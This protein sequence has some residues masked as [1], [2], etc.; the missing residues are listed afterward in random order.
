MAGVVC[1]LTAADLE[2]I[3]PYWGHAIKDRPV[4][5]VD[6]VRFAGEP[7]AAVAAEDEGTALAALERIHVEYEDRPSSARWTR[8]CRRRPLLHEGPLRPGLFHGLGEL[9]PL[10]G[11]VCCL[12]HRP[13]E[14]EAVFATPT[15]SSRAS[16]RSGRLPV[17]DGDTRS[18]PRWRATRSR[19]GPPASTRFSSA[20]RSPPSSSADRQRPHRCPLPR[21]RLRRRSY[22]KMEPSRSRSRA[23]PGD[24]CAS[25]TASPS[26]WSPPPAWDALPHAHGDERRGRLLGARSTAG[27]TRGL[28]RQ[29]PAR[30]ATAGDAA[31]PYRWEAY[32]VD[33]ACVYTNTA[34]A[35][36]YRA[37]GATHLQWIGELQVD[38]LARRAGLDPLDVRRQSLCTP[39][40]E[41]RAGGKPLDAD[42]VGDVEVAEAIGWNGERKAGMGRGLSVSLPPPAHTGLERRRPHG[43]RRQWSR[44]HHRSRPGR[45]HRFR[46]DR[47]RGAASAA[48]ARD[49]AR[50]TALYAVRPLDRRQPLDDRAG[51]AVKR[52]AE[53]VRAQ[54]V[55][56]AGDEDVQSDS[57]PELFVRHFGL[58]GG[59][60]IGRGRWR[61]RNRAPTRKARLL[62]GLRRSSRGRHRRGHGTRAR[63]QDRNRG[64]RWQG[65]QPTARRAP[66]RRRHAAGSATRCTR[67]WSTRTACC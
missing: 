17:R 5:A 4:V 67:R 66:G 33:A 60:L 14:P 42:L 7:V 15:T 26:R 57:Y 27:S 64:R 45:P 38:E 53:Q 51:M 10:D 8:R 37:F 48:R 23:R 58:A 1:V 63:A 3:D 25:R 6:C 46:T 61:L 34:P 36:S 52:A 30:A 43:G 54:L 32:R 29:R 21:R 31:R 62:G 55:E 50:R 65:D 39:G 12:P 24:R 59:E 41:L 49:R 28:R 44:R 2:D 35:G 20:P 19:S 9:K 11:N 18:S 56:I 40:D 13:G 22:T 16:T 47:G